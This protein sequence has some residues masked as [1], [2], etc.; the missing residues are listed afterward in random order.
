MRDC[1]Y[2]GCM[3]LLVGVEGFPMGT[4]CHVQQRLHNKWHVIVEGIDKYEDLFLDE[5]N[6]SRIT[7][8]DEWVVDM[9]RGGDSSLV[10]FVW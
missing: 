2:S 9:Y 8:E 1:V 3:A 7:P 4:T 5:Q 10:I 6:L